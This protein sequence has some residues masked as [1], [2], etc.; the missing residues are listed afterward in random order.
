MTPERAIRR[1]VICGGGTA[2][3]MSAAALSRMLPAQEIAVTLVQSSDIGTVGVGEATIPPIVQFNRLLGID[4]D[5]FLAATNATFKLGIEFVDWRRRGHTY[6]HPFGLFGADMHEVSFHHFWRR[7]V[8][9]GMSDAVMAFNAEMQLAYSGK[10]GPAG[11]AAQLR[12]PIRCRPPTDEYL[13]QY[14]VRNGVRRDRRQDRKRRA[15]RQR[16][17]RRGRARRW[18]PA[19]GRL[20]HRLHGFSRAADRA[21]H[22]HRVRGLEPM[23]AVQ[24][25]ACHAVR[26]DVRALPV[27]PRTRAQ[28]WGWRWQIPLQHRTGNGMVYCDAFADE[29]EVEQALRTQIDGAPLADPNP[30]RF[31]A[32]HCVAPWTGNCLAIGLSSGFLE[33]LESTSIHLIQ[34]GILSFITMFPDRLPDPAMAARYNRSME[35]LQVG[36][37][38]FIIAHYKLT[39]RDDTPFWRHVSAMPIPD[40]LAERLE[41]FE[42]RGEVLAEHGDLFKEANWFAVLDG[43]GVRARSWHP[44]AD[45][46]PL[47]ELRGRMD[48]IA[49]LIANRARLERRQAN[50][51]LDP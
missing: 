38:D 15:R 4:E 44:A 36:M 26:K 51:H 47:E 16:R 21:G 31:I 32:R 8:A 1:I 23:A 18:P 46:P 24:P 48:Q 39:Q 40:S 41:L 29:A 25:R 7:A 3:W 13:R 5:E 22:G 49:S 6:M 2:G 35:R 28:D 33:P 27:H 30:L 20:L 9:N 50:P 37:R 11:A 34:A 10:R 14:A 12:L 17:H 45:L 43:M 42:R 19:R